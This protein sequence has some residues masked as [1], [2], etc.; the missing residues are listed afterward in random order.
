MWKFGMILGVICLAATLVLAVTYEMTKPKIEAQM[1]AEESEALKKIMPSAG[2]FEA[3]TAGEIEYFEA[4][5]D[6][7]LI[8]YCLKVTGTGYGGYIRMIVGIDPGGIIKGVRVLEH[9]ETP[10]LG[11]GISDLRPGESES[12]FLRQLKGKQARTVAVKRDVDAVT[13]ATIS[14]K[15]VTDAIN[16]AVGEFLSKVKR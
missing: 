15:A 12:R 13:G 9:Q 8:G 16:K 1:K 10:G 6:G 4:L 14:S 11:S 5:K 2:S 7:T 3:K